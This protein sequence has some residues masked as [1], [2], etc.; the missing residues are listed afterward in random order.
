MDQVDYQTAAGLLE[1]LLAEVQ[2]LKGNAIQ[3]YLPVIHGRLGE[4]YFHGG[5]I[6]E[7]TPSFQS[8]AASLRASQDEEGVIAYLGSLYEIHRYLAGNEQAAEY[9]TRLAGVLEASGRPDE[10]VRF[11]RQAAIVRAGE[12]LNRVVAVVGGRY[13]EIG[14]A[15]LGQGN[16]IQFVFERNRIVLRPPR[17]S[18]TAAASSAWPGTSTR[19]SSRS[20]KLVSWTSMILIP[21]IRWHSL[22]CIFSGTPTQSRRTGAS[23]SVPPAGS[24]VARGCG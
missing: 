9:A 7:S 14:E 24:T 10:A 16:Q 8:G 13:H 19:L 3:A 23:R 15:P 2:P 6:A 1:D 18:P 22:T 20:R 12:P 21:I 5:A 17:R 4:C 11:R